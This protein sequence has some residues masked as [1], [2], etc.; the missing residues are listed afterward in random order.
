MW[1]LKLLLD[2]NLIVN[3]HT[4]NGYSINPWLR[5]QNDSQ[6]PEFMN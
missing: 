1:L 6:V 4:S 3:N 2:Q 5:L